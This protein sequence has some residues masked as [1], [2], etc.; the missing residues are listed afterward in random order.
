LSQ[1]SWLPSLENWPSPLENNLE[2]SM[3]T[4]MFSFTLKMEEAHSSDTLLP[5]YLSTR[6]HVREDSNLGKILV[7][8]H[9]CINHISVYSVSIYRNVS[10]PN[11]YVFHVTEFISGIYSEILVRAFNT[12][13]HKN[14]VIHSRINW[15]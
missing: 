7:L 12:N 3:F 8:L 5:F 1:N 10:K 9:I 14:P 13:S 11:T 15:N 6:L 4:D 2:T